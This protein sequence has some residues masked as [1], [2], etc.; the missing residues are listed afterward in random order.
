MPVPRSIVASAIAAAS[1]G[2]ASYRTVTIAPADLHV[3]A[4]GLRDSKS[5]DGVDVAVMVA[6]SNGAR[7]V[8]RK[9]HA[10]D[11]VRYDG[12]PFV[13]R[14]LVQDCVDDQSDRCWLVRN[15][16]A[17]LVLERSKL[18]SPGR[19]HPVLL[20]TATTLV[21]GGLI[22]IPVSTLDSVDRYPRLQTGLQVWGG[23]SATIVGGLLVWAI[24]DC[25]ILDGNCRD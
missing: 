9:V 13:V 14:D 19:G 4:A 24:V 3:Q 2:C 15:K 10:D 7:A 5:G 1:A 20:G 16:N 8:H 21:L 12:E 18:E 17:L 11:V 25:F 6:D 22:A 23:T